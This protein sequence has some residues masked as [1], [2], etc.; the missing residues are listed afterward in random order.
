MSLV[1]F[2][3]PAPRSWPQADR[4]LPRARCHDLA[5]PSPATR[6]GVV[7]CLAISA[8][9]LLLFWLIASLPAAQALG[10]AAG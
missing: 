7:Y 3:R 8:A 9:A 4:S 2:V 6:R 10:P 5:P 1:T